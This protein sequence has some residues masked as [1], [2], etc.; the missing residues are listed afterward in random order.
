M[1]DKVLEFLGLL[2]SKYPDF[3]VIR[4]PYSSE[5][6]DSISSFIHILGVPKSMLTQVSEASW[7][8]ALD[9]FKDE[10]IPF[11]LTTV[12]PESS[13]AHFPDHLSSNIAQSLPA[14]GLNWALSPP[15]SEWNKFAV[16]MQKLMEPLRRVMVN[17]PTIPVNTD[18]VRAIESIKS[19]FTPIIIDL[20]RLAPKSPNWVSATR[21]LVAPDP[22]LVVTVSSKVTVSESI[23]SDYAIAA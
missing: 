1:S 15:W 9:V 2:E 12:D 13:L 17:V 11:L 18:L 8:L 21:A 4:L 3:T 10:P 22:D 14:Q 16:E 20:G 5:G 6:D 7:S 19:T 23:A